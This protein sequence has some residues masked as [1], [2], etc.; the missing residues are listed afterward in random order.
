M[1]RDCRWGWVLVVGLVAGCAGG[2][3]EGPDAATDD[4]TGSDAVE[5]RDIRDGDGTHPDLP[6]DPGPDG[7]TSDGVVPDHGSA[8][9]LSGTDPGSGEVDL[10]SWCDRWT[11]AWCGFQVR[12]GWRASASLGACRD[13]LAAECPGPW[14]PAIQDEGG[15]AF[16]P[17][18][19]ASCLQSLAAT[20]C[21]D[22]WATFREARDPFPA[23]ATVL[24]G[25]RSVGDGCSWTLECPDHAWCDLSSCPGRCRAFA[26]VGDPCDLDRPCDPLEAF[27]REGTCA[28]LPGVGDPCP[29]GWCLS[30]LICQDGFCQVPGGPGEACRPGGPGCL[31]GLVCRGDG[32]GRCDP[33]GASGDPCFRT[34]ECAD[35]A[36]RDVLTCVSGRC[37]EAPGPGDPCPDLVCGNAW[38][39]S[40]GEVPTC[41][42]LPAEGESCL[43][44][45]LCAEGLWCHQGRCE[46]SLTDGSPCE[47]P[48]QCASGRC[49][50]GHCRSPGA[51]PCP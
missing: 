4:G 26:A 20:V 13:A 48:W 12:C 3:T 35:P 32:E 37:R 42:A 45:I 29:D 19:A 50:A 25:L 1:E 14:L 18:A 51:L 22:W 31:Q 44:G 7:A 36:G 41:R 47:G 6:A 17:L 11:A 15:L 2:S 9:D 23:C 5:A 10:A 34:V 38:C 8:G 40:G 27:C 43:Q 33:P 16:D 30:P 28:A 46:V 21:Q 49:V 24:R 39:D